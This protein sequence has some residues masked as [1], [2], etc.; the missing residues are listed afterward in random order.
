M[1]DDIKKRFNDDGFTV[2]RGL[3]DPIEIEF[4]REV[5]KE[6]IKERKQFD[7]RNLEDKSEYEKSFIQCQSLWEDNLEIRKLTFDQRIQ[8][9]INP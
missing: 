9:G 1:H 2:V 4:Y 8:N 3:L 5:V 7:K 6:A